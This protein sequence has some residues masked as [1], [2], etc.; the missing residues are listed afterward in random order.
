MIFPALVVAMAISVG[1]LLFAYARGLPRVVWVAK[2]LASTIFL[3]AALAALLTAIA[4]RV[5][6]RLSR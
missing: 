5:R 2:P 1:A 6:D 3:L 4:P